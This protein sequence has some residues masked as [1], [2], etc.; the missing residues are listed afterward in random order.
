ML[1]ATRAVGGVGERQALVVAAGTFLGLTAWWFWPLPLVCS[2]HTG[3]RPPTIFEE[4][5]VY[6]VMWALAWVAHTLPSAPWNLFHAN[7]FYPSTGALAYSEHFLG[8]QP[9]FAP[10]YWLSGN[11]VLATNLLLMAN[12]FLCALTAYLLAR[13]FVGSPAALVAGSSPRSAPGATRAS[14]TSTC[15]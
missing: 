7:A 14:S 2:T 15:S 12:Q 5:D 9:L 8:F 11:P 13:R 4:A 1:P 3:H 10:V 6:L